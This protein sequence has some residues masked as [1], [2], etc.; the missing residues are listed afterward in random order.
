MEDLFLRPRQIGFGQIEWFLKVQALSLHTIN[1][2]ISGYVWGHINEIAFN[3]VL[4]FMCLCGTNAC[5]Y[6]YVFCHPSLYI[7][8]EAYVNE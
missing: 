2:Y 3:N 4:V 8:S 6:V 5:T 1:G 7:T